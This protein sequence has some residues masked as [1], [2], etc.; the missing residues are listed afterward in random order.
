[1]LSPSRVCR[2]QRPL[3]LADIAYARVVAPPRRQSRHR[4]ERYCRCRRRECACW[5]M[6]VARS[7]AALHA[8]LQ[9][10]HLLW[11]E[12]ETMAGQDALI[13]L[14]P[15]GVIIQRYHQIQAIL[16]ILLDH[17]DSGGLAFEQ[18]G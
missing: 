2:N 1:M 4:R 7:Q 11:K 9:R 5:L 13:P 17:F 6:A 16:E 12:K 3:R 15:A 8:A 10:L 18:I 14:L